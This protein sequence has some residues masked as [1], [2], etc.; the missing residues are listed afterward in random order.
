MSKKRNG[1][2]VGTDLNGIFNVEDSKNPIVVNPKSVL[3]IE[4]ALE[5]IVK[6]M[7]A[8]GIREYTVHNYET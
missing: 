8:S 5:I 7:R 3:S 4:K 2:N 1:L 6:Q